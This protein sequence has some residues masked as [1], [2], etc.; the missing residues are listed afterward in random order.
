M[1]QLHEDDAQVRKELAERE[2]QSRLRIVAGML[3]NRGGVRPMTRKPM[4]M[5]KTYVRSGLSNVVSV[6]P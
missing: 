3:L 6:E 1:I 2:R 5:E 4:Y